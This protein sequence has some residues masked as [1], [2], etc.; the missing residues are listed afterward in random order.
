MGILSGLKNFGINLNDDIYEDNKAKA[1][2]EEDARLA[3]KEAAEAQRKAAEEEKKKKLS[4]EPTYLL[5]KSYTCPVCD[6]PFKSLAVKA[7][8]SRVVDHDIDLRP[9]YEPVD[10][11]KYT[12]VS[13]PNCGYSALTRTFPNITANQQKVVREKISKNFLAKPED[14]NKSIYT[15]EEALERYELAFATAMATTAKTSEKAYLCLSM[16]WLVRGQRKALDDTQFD[17][18]DKYMEYRNTERELQKKALE[19]FVYAVQTENFPMCGGMD[20]HTVDYIIAAMYYKTR[21]FDKAMKILPDILISAGANKRIKDKARDL[22][23]KILA[24]KASNVIP[25]EDD[26]ED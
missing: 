5:A 21:E 25:E 18:V 19:G 26:L 23:D 9:K 20:Q 10:T 7:N 4:E 3:A 22:K 11:L 24:I 12:V 13:C 6:K 1:N 14:S 15:Y 8:R 16:A 17:Y 2:A